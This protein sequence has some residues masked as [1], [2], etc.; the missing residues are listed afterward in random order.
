MKN[1]KEYEKSRQE[2]KHSTHICSRRREKTE[3]KNLKET[4]KGKQK[5]LGF[6]IQKMY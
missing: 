4:L 3:G 5:N 6:Q 2:A 1:R